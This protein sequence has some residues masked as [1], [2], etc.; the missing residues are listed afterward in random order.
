LHQG[1]T[2][3]FGKARRA[4]LTTSLDCNYDP[5][6]KWDSGIRDV[7]KETD[8]F[9]PNEDEARQLCGGASVREAAAQLAQWARIVAVK[10]GPR[11]V[12]VQTAGQTIEVPGVQVR[13]LETAGAGDCF[14]AGF[15]ARFI[16]GA[17]LE[18]CARAGVEAGARAVSRG[19]GA[20]AF[21]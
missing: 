21:S 4:G 11:G 13:V 20:A 3:L 16:K 12:L 9:F 6:E 2:A 10:R 17:S 19:G 1:A 14:N 15:L 8:I 18:E 5:T 7:L